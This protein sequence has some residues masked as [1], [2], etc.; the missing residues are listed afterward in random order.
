MNGHQVV[1]PWDLEPTQ[2]NIARLQQIVKDL[3]A[4]HDPRTTNIQR[5]QAQSVTL[6]LDE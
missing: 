3:E 2:E 1:Q 4:V 5:L 6:F